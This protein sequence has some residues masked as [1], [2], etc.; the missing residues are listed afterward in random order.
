MKNKW[1]VVAGSAVLLAC[2]ALGGNSFAESDRG[3]I[4][5]GTIRIENRSEADFPDMARITLE[6]AIQTAHTEVQGQVLKAE[7][8]DEDGFLD[9]NIEVVTADRNILEVKV[10]A[11][12]GKVLAKEMDRTDQ[13]NH[14]A[15]ENCDER[16]DED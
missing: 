9:Y 7:L 13:D 14:E 4:Q 16:D 12:S 10:D 3:E 6:Q 1:M 15:E 5:N 2:L 11:G 8:E